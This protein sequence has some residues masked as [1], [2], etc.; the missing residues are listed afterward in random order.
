M[1]ERDFKLQ[2]T[3]CRLQNRRNADCGMSNAEFRN[4]HSAFR[5]GASCLLVM[6][7]VG[8]AISQPKR[9]QWIDPL[10]REPTSYKVWARTHMAQDEVTSSGMVLQTGF[11][12]VVEVVVNAAIYPD[13]TSELTQYTSDLVAAGWSVRIDTMRGTRAPALRSLLQ[14]VTDIKGT[15][16][17]GELP[18]AWYYSDWGGGSPE[19]FPCDLYFADLD[20]TWTDSN[21]DGLFDG[22]TGNVAPEIWVGRLYTRPLTWDDEVRLLKHYFYKNHLYRTGGLVLPDRGLC[23]NDED[24]PGNGNCGLTAIYPSVTVIEDGTTTAANYRTQLL[25]GFEWI[26]VMAHSSA[27]GSTFKDQSGNYTGTVFNCE[28]YALQPHCHFYDL[29]C[30]S[31]ARFTEEDYSAGWMVFNDD[32]GLFA[33]GSTKTGSMLPGTF[34]DYYT[35]I[36]NGS[37]VGDAFKSWFINDGESSPDWHY[38]LALIGDPT[39][40]PRH[41]TAD[42]APLTA[43]RDGGGQPLFSEAEKGA[44]PPRPLWADIV[45][46]D[47]QTD[48]NPVMTTAPDGK[49][50]VVWVS[51]RST[52]D[53]RFDIY[54]AYHTT[55]GWSAVQQIGSA[56]YWEYNPALA[57]D[58][59]GHPVLVWSVFEDS[60]HYTLHYSVWN[61]SAWSSSTQI[62]DNASEDLQSTLTRDSTGKVW[63]FW[64]NRHGPWGDVWT[65]YW[66]GSVWSSATRVTAGDTA[67][68]MYLTSAADSAGRPWVFYTRYDQGKNEIWGNY[69]TGSAWVRS[70]P[71]SGTQQRAL[72]PAAVRDA[73]GK[74]WVTWH[75][76]DGGSSEVFA[77]HLAGGSWSTPEPVST[78]PALNVCPAIACDDA[79]EPCVVWQSNATGNWNVYAS[80]YDAGYWIAPTLVD[81]NG[82]FN[83]NPA[84]SGSAGGTPWIAWQDYQAGGNWEIYAKSLPL[85]GISD[86]PTRVTDGL[87]LLGSPNPSDGPAMIRYSTGAAGFGRLAVYD[88]LGRIAGNLGI[89]YGAGT[90]RCPALPA[91][92]Y[93]ARL[94]T[95]S[96]QLETKLVLTR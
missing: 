80:H 89:V 67:L 70:G 2:I 88:R 47:P 20:G 45:C 78:G 90:I 51:G 44:V 32:W 72:R 43:G 73:A 17:V 93:F 86:G 50:W 92:V 82:G 91:G 13:L 48:A 94:V 31:G 83:L 34:G 24:W 3:D 19:E 41:G 42:R 11:S 68:H 5:I 75:S 27:W 28:M 23:F 12:N 29:F 55:S 10:G 4:P 65:R 54:G 37:C 22:H 85:S 62:A 16:L 15:V 38:G 56:D 30:C 46:P 21:N 71:V 95:G 49:V 25:N 69:Y 74:L 59:A 7:A 66:N 14:S 33:V 39:L 9:L 6:F 87:K 58:N 57:I 1:K 36:S 26:H 53:G 18:I 8:F 76:F 35:P 64:Q 40:K 63:C 52:V 61:G 84:I 81:S 77:C 79:G 96:S 60:Y